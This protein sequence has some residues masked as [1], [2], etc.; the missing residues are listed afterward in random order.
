M[1]LMT[2]EEY[3]KSREFKSPTGGFEGAPGKRLPNSM[4]YG[5]QGGSRFGPGTPGG[6]IPG[7]GGG[8]GAGGGGGTATG[9]IQANPY[10][11]K[12]FKYFE[13]LWGKAGEL[14]NETYNKEPAIQ[15]YQRMRAQ[16]L[17]ELEAGAGGRGFG[18]GTGMSLAQM[19]TYGQG[20][21]QGAQ[22]LAG[23]LWNAGLNQRTALLSNMAN[24][25]GGLGGVGGNIAS[26]QLGLSNLG[27]GYAQLG[28]DT[29][30]KQQMLALE[31]AK[32]SRDAQL[33]AFRYAAPHLLSQA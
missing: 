11:D 23:N 29:L 32:A 9:N 24:I 7:G 10:L 20:T 18:P 12:A 16:G 27:L 8:G 2:P 26:N 19:Q 3:R 14:E 13:D 28:A 33:E 5:T 4:L 6:G 1:A 31:Q 30:Y 25:L 17:K 15:D 22:G 21:E